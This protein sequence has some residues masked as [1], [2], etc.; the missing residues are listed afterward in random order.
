MSN[1][2]I[3][4]EFFTKQENSLGADNEIFSFPLPSS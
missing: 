1:A 2:Q 3:K 4:N